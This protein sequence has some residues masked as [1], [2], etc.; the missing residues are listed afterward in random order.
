M[1]IDMNDPLAVADHDTIMKQEG[2]FVGYYGS[3]S[4]EDVV[5]DIKGKLGEDL[6]GQKVLL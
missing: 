4:I 5:D 6:K 2:Y 3:T 1:K